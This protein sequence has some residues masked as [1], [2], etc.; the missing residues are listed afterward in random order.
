MSEVNGRE[1][2]LTWSCESEGS[3]EILY[4]EKGFWSLIRCSPNS[5]GIIG[6][7][8]ELLT[9]EKDVVINGCQ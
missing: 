8:S 2:V 7:N 5:P 4:E 6:E 9:W 3:G 1:E